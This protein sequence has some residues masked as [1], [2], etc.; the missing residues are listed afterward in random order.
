MRRAGGGEAL[1]SAGWSRCRTAAP[2]AADKEVRGA[3]EATYAVLGELPADERIAF[4]LRFIEG[5]ELTEVAASCGVSLA[6]I[7]RRIGRA[8]GRF[9]EKARRHPILAGRVEGGTRWTASRQG[10]TGNSGGT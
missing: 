9:V 1:S 2:V 3:L 10:S 5:M 6:T 8:E 4:A 7:K